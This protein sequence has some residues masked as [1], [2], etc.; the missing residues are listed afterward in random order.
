VFKSKLMR[1]GVG[2]VAILGAALVLP[3]CII[4]TAPYGGTESMPDGH[5]WDV[6]GFVNSTTSEALFVKGLANCNLS[7][8][9]EQSDLI[10]VLSYAG[11][12]GVDNAMISAVSDCYPPLGNLACGQQLY[13]AIVYDAWGG[14]NGTS[15]LLAAITPGVGGDVVK[16][17]TFDYYGGLAP[18]ASQNSGGWGVYP[19][20][21]GGACPL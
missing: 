17:A 2:L 4:T 10:S 19:L 7:I 1:R 13:Q 14:S 8:S 18:L 5:T 12:G 21:F 9:C 16:T 15:C 11:G 20:G 6:A 3:A